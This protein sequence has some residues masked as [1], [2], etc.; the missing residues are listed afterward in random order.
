MRH[1]KRA[2][3][4]DVRTRRPKRSGRDTE[5]RDVSGWPEATIRAQDV[6]SRP[7]TTFRS[8]MTVGA[9]VKAMR[10]RKIRHA[11]VL[12]RSGALAGIVSDGDL[13]QVVLDPAVL[14][15]LEELG[16]T[17]NARTL[18][19]VMT[20]SPI[21]VKPTTTLREVAAIMQANRI[22]AVPVVERRRVVGLLTGTDV[23]KAVIRLMDEG[24]ISKPGRWGAEA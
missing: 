14:E 16:R 10:L 12:D 23:L 20:W 8:E 9:A 6:M 7:V 1:P 15:G 22:G 13:R 21:S 4:R 11:P 5:E 18:K 24:V 17:L 2:I 19:D 3:T